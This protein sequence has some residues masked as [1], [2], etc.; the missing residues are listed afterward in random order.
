MDAYYQPKFDT[1]SMDSLR[2]L[3]DGIQLLVAQQGDNLPIPDGAP[4]LLHNYPDAPSI[5]STSLW[6]SNYGSHNI[7]SGSAVLSWSLGGV[8]H[9]GTVVHVCNGSV[10]LTRTVPQGPK[11]LMVLVPKLSCQLPDLGES[12]PPPPSPGPL[13][14]R[15]V[16]TGPG[17]N[18][19]VLKT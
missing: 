16:P 17:W 13:P 15:P 4:R 7:S 3:N 11:G 10:P 8:A 6:I 18:G 12:P 2:H 1:T 19:P 5:L 9:N 14:P